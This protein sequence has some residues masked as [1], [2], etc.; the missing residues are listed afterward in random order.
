MPRKRM[1]KI[2][3]NISKNHSANL[4]LLPS[5]ARLIAIINQYF[6]EIGIEITTLLQNEF[7][8]LQSFEQTD[9]INYDVKIRNIRFQG[10]LAKFGIYLEN[11]PEKIIDNMKVCLEN[12][13]G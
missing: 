4:Q 8:E 9:L 11:N 13:Q 1:A 5:F 12:F 6:P 2:L 10:E 3:F 7:L